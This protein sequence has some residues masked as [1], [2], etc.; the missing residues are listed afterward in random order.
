MITAIELRERMNAHPFKPFRVYLSDGRTYDITNHDMMF[1]NRNTIFI[2]VNLD[3]N[4]LAERMVQ[5]PILHIT[6]I[7][8]IVTK[9]A[10]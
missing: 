2:G 6:G 10:A 8:D 5:C 3:D 9:Q 4:D 7:E 1:V